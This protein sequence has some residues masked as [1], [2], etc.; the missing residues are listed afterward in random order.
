M[1]IDCWNESFIQPVSYNQWKLTKLRPI[2][3]LAASLQNKDLQR[4]AIL[5]KLAQ[6]K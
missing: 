3:H 5:T 4:L 2:R 6:Q 1:I